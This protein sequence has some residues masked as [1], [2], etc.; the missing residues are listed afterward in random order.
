MFSRRSARMIQAS[1]RHHSVREAFPTVY[2]Q[3]T[4]ASRAWQAGERC[5]QLSIS[6]RARV[7]YENSM[8]SAT[9]GQVATCPYAP[10]LLHAISYYYQSTS[11]FLYEIL[12]SGRP[13][14]FDLQSTTMEH[15]SPIRCSMFV[16]VAANGRAKRFVKSVASPSPLL[17]LFFVPVASVPLL[18]VLPHQPGWGAHA[19]QRGREGEGAVF[20]WP[21]LDM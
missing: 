13:Q 2:S 17:P 7:I 15:G 9:S 18:I 16:L 21:Q 12:A 20:P 14:V 19:A 5:L 11:C 1:S 8:P 4:P 6:C 3:G 10:L